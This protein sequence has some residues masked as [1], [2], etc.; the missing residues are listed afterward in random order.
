MDWQ[1]GRHRP[2]LVAPAPRAFAW[3]DDPEVSHISRNRRYAG[4]LRHPYDCVAAA[5]N[6]DATLKPKANEDHEY[7]RLAGASGVAYRG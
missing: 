3:P 1:Q 4:F 6:R 7:R 5:S 2:N